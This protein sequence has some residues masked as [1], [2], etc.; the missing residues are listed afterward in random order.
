[1]TLHRVR[2]PTLFPPPKP[3]PTYSFSY[4]S[5]QLPT[6]GQRLRACTW[7]CEKEPRLASW[8]WTAPPLPG[9]GG[10]RE[11]GPLRPDPSAWTV[12][13]LWPVQAGR[14]LLL[15]GPLTPSLLPR[16][17]VGWRQGC[18]IKHRTPSSIWISHEQV[19]F[20]HITRDI[21]ILEMIDPKSTVTF[22]PKASGTF[23]NLKKEREKENELFSINPF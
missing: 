6:L 4:L 20:R 13:S 8:S 12:V 5:L 3:A 17:L 23:L 10:L 7:G 9:V 16:P 11:A 2:L 19:I 21:L 18:Q 22:S 1:M 14:R 15:Q